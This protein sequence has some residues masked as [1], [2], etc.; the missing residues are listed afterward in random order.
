MAL[1]YL[2]FVFILLGVVAS[3][4][5]RKFG[6]QVTLGKINDTKA[7]LERNTQMII[8]WGVKNGRLPTFTDY[9]GS[10]G[11][12]PLDAWGNPFVFAYYSSLTKVSTGGVCGLTRTAI[13]YNGQ[14]VAFLLLSGSDDMGVTSTPA[15]NGAFSGALTAL[16]AEDL[17]RIV[18]LKELQEQAGCFGSTEGKLR[19]V[20]NELPGACK[21][22][23]YSATIIGSGGVPP[24]TSYTFAGLPIGLAN[25]GATIF[26]NT[27]TARGQ[28]PVG[29]VMTDTAATIV[30]RSYI[31]NIMSSCY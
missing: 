15:I 6:A 4:G 12:K 21:R 27:T 20:N 5:V 10:F 3:F 30:K 18:T 1:L 31:L 26:G 24:Y 29:V 25:S 7:G 9:S 14:D 13:T 8:A 11:A 16:K 19:I 28:Y 2:V 22:V 23:N 17:F